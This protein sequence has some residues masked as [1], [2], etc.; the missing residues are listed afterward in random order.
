MRTLVAVVALALGILVYAALPAAAEEKAAEKS[1]GG[2]AARIQD[3]NLT[4]EQEAKIADIRKEYKPKVQ[5]AGKELASVVKEEVEKVKGVLTAEQKTKLEEAK[6][7]RKERRAEGLSE[8]IAHVG[9]LDLT[10]SEITKIDEIRKEFRPK[11]E[12]AMKELQGLLSDDQKKAREEAL[13]AG[14]KRREVIEA[15]KL[16]DEQKEK[17]NNVG[18]DVRNLVREEME[19]IRDVLSE[20]QRAKLLE[21]KEERKELVRDRT[22]CRI[23]NLKDLNLTDE[24]KTQIADIRKDYRPKVQEAGNKLRTTAR[25]EVEAILAAIKG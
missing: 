16:T 10:D 1:G 2:L 4:D 5:E 24:Q 14:K 21:L 19:K 11:I 12:K 22:A 18:K 15:L 23:A 20:E 13:K 25:E 8:R 9:Q 6:E 17:I 7:E 3:L